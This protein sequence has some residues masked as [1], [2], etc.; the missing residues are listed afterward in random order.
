MPCG[1]NNSV[2]IVY[3]S[4]IIY[5]DEQECTADLPRQISKYFTF[6]RRRCIIMVHIISPT[7]P[8]YKYLLL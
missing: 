3:T 8:W 4:H 1:C 6:Q 5:I 2:E 7:Q